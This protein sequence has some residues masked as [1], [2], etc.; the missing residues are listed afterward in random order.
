MKL[1]KIEKYSMLMNLSLVGLSMS[2]ILGINV[3]TV[4]SPVL[5]INFVK[6]H[7]D[8]EV[9]LSMTLLFSRMLS[10]VKRFHLSV[11]NNKILL[12]YQWGIDAFGCDCW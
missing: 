11:M 12:P 10:L 7:T 3:A 8:N 4:I 5:H 6:I 1:G 2:D 9:V